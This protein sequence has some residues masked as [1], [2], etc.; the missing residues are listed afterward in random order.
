MSSV[1]RRIGVVSKAESREAIA[2]AH[3]VADWLERRGCVVSLDEA[4]SRAKGLR[5]EVYSSEGEYDLVVVLGGDGTLLATARGLGGRAP[6][7]GVNL[8]R[9]GFLTELRRSELYPGLLRVLGGEF[10]LE[11]RS[12][13]DVHLRRASG[14]VQAY[15]A[16]NDAVVAKSSPVR[17]IEVTLRC[18]GQ[19]VASYRADGVILSTPTGSTA[20]NL[21][22]GGPIIA[23]ALPVIVITPICPHTLSLRPIVVPDTTAIEVQLQTRR[24]EVYLTCDGQEGTTVGFQDVV[25]VRSSADHVRLVRVAGRSVFDSLREK[26]RWGGLEDDNGDGAVWPSK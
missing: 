3:E 5:G 8:G 25:H 18:D 1:L 6:I 9:L 16:L 21:S 24:E 2:T 20:Y 14:G 17:I 23:P 4:T 26:L 19:E 7:L 22:A 15:R 13:L 11:R 10:R 12:L